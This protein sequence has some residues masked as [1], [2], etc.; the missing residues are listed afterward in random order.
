VKWPAGDAATVSVTLEVTFVQKKGGAAPRVFSC[1]LE[2]AP[3]R[4]QL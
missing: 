2:G 1:S 3:F 4:S